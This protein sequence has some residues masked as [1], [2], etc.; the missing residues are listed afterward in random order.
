M[1]KK[2][3]SK[4]SYGLL[5]FIFLVF[6]APLITNLLHNPFNIKVLIVLGLLIIVFGF[7]LHL[8]FKTEYI[9]DNK[10][11]RIRC[12]IFSY[13]PIEIDDIKEVSKTNNLISS[14]APSFDRIEIKYGKF[15]TIIISPKDK[16]KFA[17][18]L[19]KI[20]PDIRNY[21]TE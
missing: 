21:I 9:I 1:V 20:N 15:D 14:P 11:L 8:F 12:G 17:K 13:K 19:R 16:S 4:I 3:S 7:I 18:D 2:Y 10:K 6:F 5:I